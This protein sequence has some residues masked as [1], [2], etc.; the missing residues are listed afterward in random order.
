MKFHTPIH[1]DYFLEA[2]KTAVEEQSLQEKSP[3][4]AYDLVS[5]NE[6]EISILLW[7]GV[8]AEG[9]LY[10]DATYSACGVGT[11]VEGEVV[12]HAADTDGATRFARY[13]ARATMALI[14]GAICYGVALAI[15]FAFGVQ[16]FVLPLVAPVVLWVAAAI[17]NGVR[18]AGTQKRLIAFLTKVLG[19][20]QA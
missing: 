19:T 8:T 3:K 18:R 11:L 2:V 6:T 20:I 4:S 5:A 13:L 14:P 7:Q 10:F 12:K 1:P 15:L 17:H 16:S 9:N